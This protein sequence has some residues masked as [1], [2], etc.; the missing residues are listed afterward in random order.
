MTLRGRLHDLGD[1][2]QVRRLLPDARRRMVGP[3]A[4]FDHIGPA[5]FA[6]GSGLDVRPHPHIGLATVTFL[7]EGALRH[8]DSL[9]S[10]QDIVPGDVNWMTAGRGIVHSERTPP[11]LR[12]SGQRLEGIQTWVALPP[13]QAECDPAFAHHAAASLPTWQSAGASLRLVAGSAYGREAPVIVFSPLFEIACT[14]A[15]G[16]EVE[17]PGEHAE[18]A[19]YVLAGDAD[20][21]GMPVHAGELLVECG[22]AP[23]RLRARGAVTALLFGGAPYGPPPHMEWNFVAAERARIE[24][25]KADWRAGRFGAV[26]GETDGIPLP[27]T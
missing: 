17:L 21:A 5:A 22:G 6:P 11:A 25:A 3:F 16:A 1:G 4:F 20:V 24:R 2:L 15:A 10:V 14:L 19:V 9:G 26:P 12:A 18:R 8:R 23:G 13:D 27:E 7:F